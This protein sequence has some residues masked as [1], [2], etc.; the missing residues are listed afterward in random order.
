MSGR[1]YD[2]PAKADPS[3]RIDAIFDRFQSMRDSIK[4]RLVRM[5]FLHSAYLFF[6]IPFLTFHFLFMQCIEQYKFV[7]KVNF[8]F[9]FCIIQFVI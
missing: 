2:S 6:C 9:Q 5:I 7:V 3:E 1:G 8:I 4:K